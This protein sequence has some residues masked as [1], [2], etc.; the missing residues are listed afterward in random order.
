MPV[1]MEGKQVSVVG[2]GPVGCTL[3]TLLARRGAEVVVWEQRPDMRRADL[4]AGRSI[5]LVLTR[6][7]LRALERV[8]L[9]EAVLD[10][11]VPVLGRMMHELDGALAYQPYG[12]DESE[13]N[14]S[15]SRGVLNCCLLDAAE[16]AGAK[17][18]FDQALV[19]MHPGADADSPT[20][21]F[22]ERP[23]SHCADGEIVERRLVEHS[24]ELVFGCDGAPSAVRQALSEFG[25]VVDR[26]EMLDY[27]YKELRF[28]AAADG[29]YPMEESALHIWPR[30]VDMLMG[31]AN[32][33]GSFTGTVYLPQSG[34]GSF[35]EL[36]TPEEVRAFFGAQYPDAVPMLGD[37]E[38]EFLEHPTG[39]LGTVRCEPFHLDGR[40]LLVG[41]AGHGIVP[42]F[43]QGLN[44]GFEDCV[45]LDD[46]LDISASLT[47]AFVTF[48]ASRKPDVDAIADLALENFVEMRD[49][50]GDPQFLLRKK[51][52][53][54]IEEQMG[55]L[56]RSRYAMVMYSFIP[57]SVAKALGEVQEEILAELTA[58][59]DEVDEVDMDLARRRIVSKLVPLY[60]RYGVDLNF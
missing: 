41:D 22:F 31:L 13:R 6:R 40:V 32:L 14:Y 33:D 54:R 16:A 48:S 52:E 44:S 9:R 59:I 43:G 56:Y 24:S 4:A 60:A 1:S 26:V 20:R 50:V 8:G 47:D 7:G 18:H 11:T 29:S 10:L 25:V 30:G 36:V 34:P 17:I 42:F 49:R 21:L 3:A 28:P 5:N 58:A 37:F 39:S 15:V 19:A 2:A 27:G 57:Y 12:K 51:V 23:N 35:A 38:A 53:H 45:V 55:E 46:L